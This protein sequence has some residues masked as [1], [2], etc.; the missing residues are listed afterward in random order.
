MSRSIAAQPEYFF[1]QQPEA[2]PPLYAHGA[3]NDNLM[4]AFVE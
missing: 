3:R 4:N 2:V 1:G